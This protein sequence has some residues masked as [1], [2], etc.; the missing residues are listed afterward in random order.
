MVLIVSFDWYSDK[1]M[2]HVV[3]LDFGSRLLCPS[4]VLGNDSIV[5]PSRPALVKVGWWPNERERCDVG[6]LG[7]AKALNLPQM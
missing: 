2:A 3:S 6:R 4:V 1:H 7:R 5:E